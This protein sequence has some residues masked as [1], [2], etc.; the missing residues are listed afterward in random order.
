[1]FFQSVASTSSAQQSD[2]MAAWMRQMQHQTQDAIFP[3][4]QTTFTA[5][6][7]A[8][9]PPAVIPPA[10]IPPAVIPPAPVIPTVATAQQ[11]SIV[12]ATDVPSPLATS[13]LAASPIVPSPRPQAPL[14]MPPIR[15]STSTPSPRPGRPQSAPIAEAHNESFQTLDTPGPPRSQNV[16]LDATDTSYSSLLKS[17]FMP[18]V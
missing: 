4:G 3:E 9:L 10:V 8:Q 17:D 6:Q 7:L 11:L 12:T 16:S 13:P 14:V 18:G 1:M 15:P 5:E 2:S